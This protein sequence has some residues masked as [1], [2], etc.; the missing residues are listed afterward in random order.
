MFSTLKRWI[1]WLI[2]W[3]KSY[4]KGDT[5]MSALA[6]TPPFPTF[7]G[8][9]GLPLED[10]YIWIGSA[11]QNPQTS[12]V[13][14]YWDEALTQ[15]AQQPIRTLGGY[16]AYSGTPARLFIGAAVYSILVQDKNANTVYNSPSNTGA[17]T[18]V[19]FSVN[20]E[21]Q[22]ATAGQTVFTLANTYSP[23][24]NSLTVYVDGVNQYDGSGYAFV[25]TSGDTV[26]FTG[27]L[28]VGAL[29]KFST[30]I[31]L[32]GGAADSSQVTYVPAGA[33]AVTTNVQA[34]L[35]ETVSVKDFGAVGDG[36][37]DD[38]P[39][40]QA[41]ID[42]LPIAGG[43]LHFPGCVNYRCDTGLAWSDKAVHII[44]DGPGFQP[45][46]G[47][48]IT[49]PAGVTGINP[50]NGIL[51]RGANSAV[52][53]IHIVGSDVSAG[54][55][56]GLLIQTNGFYAKN[57][58]VS[59]F[60]SH[61]IYVFSSY[62]LDN[63]AL[64][65][66]CY[67]IDQCRSYANFGS[68]FATFG[69]NSNCGVVNGLDSSNNAEW[70][71]YDRAFLG[72]T[73]IG[74]HVAG[75][76]QGGYRF[77][78]TGGYVRI[79]GG[80]AEPDSTPGVQIDLANTGYNNLDFLQMSNSVTDNSASNGNRITWTASA[81]VITDNIAVGDATARYVALDINGIVIDRGKALTLLNALQ[82]ANWSI[83]VNASQQLAINSAQ[84][85][86]ILVGNQIIASGL[87][88]NV[89]APTNTGGVTYGGTT[90]ST[91]GAAGAASALPATPLGY[92]I[93]NVNSTQVKI[94][95]YNT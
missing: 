61:G 3:F 57:V 45:G 83:A 50:Q 43:T 47:T 40:I 92:I 74:P 51:G 58:Y 78:A 93:C 2:A 15:I 59:G 5:V 66:N 95:Y 36:V 54:S 86:E 87:T 46:T 42:S 81:N 71:I 60:G 34:K 85:K 68:G 73:Y 67:Q 29:V 48:R 53:N 4:F 35:R 23:G 32:S 52:E 30:A 14:A 65:A 16:P 13:V 10:G 88:A 26:T 80:Y 12:P 19:N 55:N 24:T 22:V 94:P 91:V 31:Q 11:N 79:L 38:Y 77:G 64:N 89:V 21:V 82:D 18:F 1:A 62:P 63:V 9:D 33:G 41:A 72:T 44:G 37:T 49:F 27:G 17:S 20:E 6:I 75:N 39:A 56:Y 8:K 84:L 69:V 70:G 76:L 7:S 90:A 25:E 28:H